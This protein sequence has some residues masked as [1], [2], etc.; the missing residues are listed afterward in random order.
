V[1]TLRCARTILRSVSWFGRLGA[2]LGAVA[3]LF[4]LLPVLASSSVRADGLV[5][6]GCVGS[7]YSFSCVKRWGSYS[8]P[9]I[10]LVPHPQSEAEKALSAERDHKW[11][12]RCHP[13]VF[14]DYYGVPRYQYAARGCEFGVI[15]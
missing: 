11:Q 10:R 7:F 12:V 15:E 4:A 13:A 8:D 6:G 1:L 3:A 9:Y 5:V 2:R 14:Q